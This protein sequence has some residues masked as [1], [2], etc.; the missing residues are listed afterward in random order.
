MYSTT[1]LLRTMELILNL[2]PMSQFDAA[3][4][5]MYRS[6][7]GKPDFTTYKHEVPNT[8]LKAVNVAAAWGA[9]WS[10]L[11][12]LDKED[13]ADDLLFNEVIWK[14]V[15]GAGSPMPPP[16]RAAFFRPIVK[17]DDDDDDDDD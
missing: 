10:E 5:P 4:T 11:A 2:K 6:F 1:S 13:Q 3:A 12:N 17:K 7:T 15:K 14:S 16:V 9:R 8:D